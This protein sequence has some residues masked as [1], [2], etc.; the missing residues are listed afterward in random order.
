MMASGGMCRIVL[1]GI[2]GY[3]GEDVSFEDV[4]FSRKFHR[5]LPYQNFRTWVICAST[6]QGVSQK[7]LD[8][9]G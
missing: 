1:V 7:S 9:F 6:I 4:F 8:H 5:Y 2:L 3:M